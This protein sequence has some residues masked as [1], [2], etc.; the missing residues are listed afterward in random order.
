VTVEVSEELDIVVGGDTRGNITVWRVSDGAQLRTQS[1]HDDTVLALALD[2]ATL[3][4]ASRDQCA[5]VWNVDLQPFSLQLRHTLLG[6]DKPVLGVQITPSYIYTSSSDHTVRIWSQ[7]S[8]KHV[9]SLEPVASIVAFKIRE[10]TAGTLLL[11]TCTD[12]TARLYNVE[13]GAELACLEG[14]TNIVRLY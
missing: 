10:T 6:H 13:T 8:G 2:K 5:K 4:S 7:K 12:S 1:A 9:R 3:V 11:G 14:H